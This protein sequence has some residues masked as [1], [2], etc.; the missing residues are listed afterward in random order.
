[1]LAGQILNR[2]PHGHLSPVGEAKAAEHLNPHFLEYRGK[3]SYGPR[4]RDEVAVNAKDNHPPAGLGNAEVTRV[5]HRVRGVISN[6]PEPGDHNIRYRHFRLLA[7]LGYEAAGHPLHVLNQDEGA[8]NDVHDLEH[9]M[10]ELIARI[11]PVA[12]P[13]NR[14]TL[15]GRPASNQ[16]NAA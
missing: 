13:A 3:V 4:A 7:R 16:A 6:F 2:L 10:H 11:L 8:A 12:A 1:M 5:D 14:E 9:A 15:A